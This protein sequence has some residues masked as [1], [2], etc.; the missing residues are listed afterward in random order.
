MTTTIRTAV[1]LALFVQGLAAAACENRA[2]PTGPTAPV[3][4]GVTAR[5]Y[6]VSIGG[7]VYDTAHRPL[8]G[9]K[10]EVIEGAVE[11]YWCHSPIRPTPPCMV[12]LVT[13]GS[14]RFGF[15]G[16]FESATRLRVSMDGYLTATLTID[17]TASNSAI[18]F[19]L[20]PS[21]VP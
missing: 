7:V 15:S 13:D 1:V 2:S 9:A 4:V 21:V 19:R 10:V 12:S 3:E 16:Q 11:G 14:G 18:E 20:E 6:S 17:S 8:H 5:V